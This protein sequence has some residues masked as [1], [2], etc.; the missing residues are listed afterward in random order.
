MEGKIYKIGSDE[1]NLI[2][3]GS[4]FRKLLVRLGNHHGQYKRWIDGKENY[5]TSF[6]IFEYGDHYIQLLSSHEKITK[7]ELRK[8]EGNE[9]LKNKD[10]CVNK[11][12]EGRT[13][14][15]YKEDNKELIKKRDKEYKETHKESIRIR[16]L[17]LYQIN[18][19]KI[20]EQKRIRREINK[21]KEKL[22]WKKFR[23]ENRE[24][25]NEK[26]RLKH[27]ENK[28]KNNKR[29]L[30]YYYKKKLEEKSII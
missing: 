20:C 25:I 30:E 8:L 18:K 7:K 9:I 10:I 12:V 23:D 11:T 19:E 17:E 28:E 13:K 2:Y 1:T 26:K 3:I 16:R 15:E 5:T 22:R 4:T 21:D 27:F 29:C 6:K 24:L 14:E